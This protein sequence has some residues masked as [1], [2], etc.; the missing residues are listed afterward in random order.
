MN[1]LGRRPSKKKMA[2]ETQNMA[3][4]VFHY[5]IATNKYMGQITAHF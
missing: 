3:V 5:D 4:D 1:S 2:E